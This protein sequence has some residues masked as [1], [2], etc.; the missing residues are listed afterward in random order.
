VHHFTEKSQQEEGIFPAPD[1]SLP[2]SDG[3]YIKD[4]K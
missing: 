4:I 1:K 3:H 2:G